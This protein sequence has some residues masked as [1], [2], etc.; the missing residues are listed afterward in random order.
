MPA[1]SIDTTDGAVDRDDVLSAR[2]RGLVP[3]SHVGRDL[4]NEL[5]RAVGWKVLGHTDD[6]TLSPSGRNIVVIILGVTR[7]GPSVR[8]HEAPFTSIPLRPSPPAGSRPP[9]PVP[10]SWLSPAMRSSK[11]G[12]LSARNSSASVRRL[13]CSPLRPSPA[14]TPIPTPL[15]VIRPLRR[16]PAARMPPLPAVALLTLVV[17]LLVPLPPA[18]AAA[19]APP[20]PRPR[21][22]PPLSAPAH[23]HHPP[24][25]GP[26]IRGDPVAGH[27]NWGPSFS[28]EALPWGRHV[29]RRLVCSPDALVCS[30]AVWCFSA[31]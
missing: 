24:P 28:P 22:L 17:V 5:L 18:P 4:L 27:P 23:L 14:T 20:P 3:P 31:R 6:S 9:T 15:G 10:S 25:R 7:V 26:L 30:Q 16:P 11:S 21:G 19:P 13:A 1:N 12:P 29:Y 2:R 8:S